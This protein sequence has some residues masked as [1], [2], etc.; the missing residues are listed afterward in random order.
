MSRIKNVKI[1]TNYR[2]KFMNFKTVKKC[3]LALPVNS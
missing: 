1:K 3:K 2:N